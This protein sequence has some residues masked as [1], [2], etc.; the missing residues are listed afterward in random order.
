MDVIKSADWI[1]DIGPDGGNNGGEIVFEGT[2]EA[3]CAEKDNFTGKHLN[4]KM[5]A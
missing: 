3:L 4:E 2:P 1:I 5:K